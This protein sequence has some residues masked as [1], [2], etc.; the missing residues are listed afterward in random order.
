MLSTTPTPPLERL[1]RHEPL[2]ASWHHQ[3]EAALQLVQGQAVASRH[4]QLLQ[5]LSSRLLVGGGRNG[6]GLDPG[7]R[8]HVQSEFKWLRVCARDLIRL[9]VCQV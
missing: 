8:R 5:L 3:R 7:E 2:A 9:P 4:E 1:V 6:G